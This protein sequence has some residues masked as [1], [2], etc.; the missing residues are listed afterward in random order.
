VLLGMSAIS[1]R[2]PRVDSTTSEKTMPDRLPGRSFTDPR[3]ALG[4]D[5]IERGDPLGGDADEGVYGRASDHVRSG[6]GVAERAK[7]VSVL[8]K[9]EELMASGNPSGDSED[10]RRRA[11]ELACGRAGVRIEEFDRY[12]KGDEELEAMMA[13]VMEAARQRATKFAAED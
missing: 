2:E 1:E 4:D 6:H 12:V 7:A 8:R 11:I 5:V 3:K 10:G 9:A 13:T